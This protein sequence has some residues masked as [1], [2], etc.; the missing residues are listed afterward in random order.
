MAKIR[1]G[2]LGQKIAAPEGLVTID[3][4]TQYAFKT[5]RVGVVDADGQFEVVWQAVRPEAPQPFPPSRS[6]EEWAA[7]LENL[8][9]QWHGHWSAPIE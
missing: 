6:H 8:H 2:M 1:E 5:P 7:F 9:T 4:A 3:P